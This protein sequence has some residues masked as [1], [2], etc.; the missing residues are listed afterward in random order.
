[1]PDYR[2]VIDP[3]LILAAL[4][5]SG[6]AFP[7][8]PASLPIHWAASGVPDEFGS[9]A[10]ATLVMPLAM[11]G[12]W[13]IC[14]VAPRYSRLFFIKY[15]VRDADLSAVR[16][17][18][19]R[20]VAG[21]LAMVLALHISGLAA[22]LGFIPPLRQA[23]VV[24]VILSFG[25]IGAGNYLPRV[26]KRN[27]LIGVRLPWTFRSDE[28]WRRSQRAAGYGLV[29]AGIV[30]VVGSIAVTGEPIKPLFIALAIQF[31]GV[32]IYSYSLAHS[33]DV[34]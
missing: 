17:T 9:R 13:V 26:T 6:I 15:T 3:S 12:L 24:G 7:Y 16:P 14:S 1:M 8:L 30:G 22:A 5:F 34:P 20:L 32:I 23:A 27:A 31:I 4:G 25:M 19:D 33:R 10:E 21:A 29:A 2:K 18:Y 11:L 28:V